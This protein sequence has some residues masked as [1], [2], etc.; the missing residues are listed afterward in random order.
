M[1]LLGNL[2]AEI[3]YT[4][5]FWACFAAFAMRLVATTQRDVESL[6]TPRQ[7]SW[8]FF[9]VD[10]IRRLLTALAL[11]VLAIRFLDEYVTGM[12][13]NLFPLAI[14][15]VADQLGVLFLYAKNKVID[16]VKG[17]IDNV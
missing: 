13:K 15:L 12:W 6:N 3:F 2:S 10:N 7:F 5:L 17:N 9:L 16:K 1:N 4:H 8:K 14:G 11:I